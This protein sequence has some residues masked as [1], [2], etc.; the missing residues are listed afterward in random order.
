MTRPLLLLDVDGVL[1]P[2]GNDMPAGY[3]EVGSLGY[4]LWL[5]VTHGERLRRLAD[6]FDLVWATTW[7]HEANQIIGPALGLNE[8]PVIEFTEGRS[9]ETWKLFAVRRYVAGRPFVWVDDELHEDA[10]EWAGSLTQPNLLIRPTR[11]LGLTDEH[12][13]QIESFGKALR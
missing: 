13:A 2:F 7:E 6:T 3:R 10:Y 4:P 12:F 5:N 1:F 8:L 9:D 11:N